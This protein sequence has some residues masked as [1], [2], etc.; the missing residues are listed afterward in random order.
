MRTALMGGAAGAALM[1]T[2][3]TAVTPTIEGFEGTRN[4]AYRDIVGVLTVCS[5][6]TGPDIII[7]KEYTAEECRKMTF[8]DVHKAAQGVLAVSP[9]LVY[10]P[11]ILASMISFTYNVGAATYAKS[12]VARNINAGD[13]SAGCAA[14]LKYTYAGGKYVDGLRI[15][16]EKEYTLCVSSLTVNG[17]KNVTP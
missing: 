13:F 6:H 1:A 3:I 16:R 2:T 10:H 5:G 11:M 4:R 8:K 12:S 9:H 17:L 7:G 14:L 15:R